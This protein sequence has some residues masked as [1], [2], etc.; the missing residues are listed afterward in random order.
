[1]VKDP[2]TSN[3][4]LL[5]N[6]NARTITLLEVIVISVNLGTLAFLIVNPVDA[7]KMGEEVKLVTINQENVIVSLTLLEISVM[8]LLKVS[9]AFQTFKNA[10]VT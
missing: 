8:K 5:E 2:L 9:T 6:V 7:I 3:V 4:I 10:H 1:M